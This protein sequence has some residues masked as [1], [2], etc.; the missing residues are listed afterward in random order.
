MK[1][2][3]FLAVLTLGAGFGLSAGPA[4]AQQSALMPGISLGGSNKPKLTPEQQEKQDRLDR[5]YKAAT[6]SQPA[7]KPVDPWGNARA[8]SQGPRM[9]EKPVRSR[10]DR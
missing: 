5:A 9:T 6:D 7:A 1:S 3:I 2:R 8:P 10:R 4:L